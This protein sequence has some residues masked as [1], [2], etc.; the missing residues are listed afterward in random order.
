MYIINKS[1][2]TIAATVN[3]GVADTNYTDLYLV[4]KNYQAY[5]Q[6]INTNFV[7]LLENFS[8][9]TPPLHPI[10]GQLWYDTVSKQLYQFNG[11]GFKNINAVAVNSASPENTQTGDFWYDTNTKQLK[12][13]TDSN[14]W[15]PVA[16]I[17]SSTQKLSG[18]VVVT[19]NDGTG[20]S[21][22]LTYLY[23]GNISIAALSADEFTPNPSIPGYTSFVRGINLSATSKLQGTATNSE[24]LGNVS[25]AGFMRTD[26]DSV[27]TGTIT[28]LNNDGVNIGAANEFFIY[29]DSADVVLE[30]SLTGNVRF[31]V[32]DAS[33]ITYT[34]MTLRQDGT[35]E[36]SYDLL[37]ANIGAT[38]DMQ[39]D[40]NLL[41]GTDGQID[42]TLTAGNVSVVGDAVAQNLGAVANVN[43]ASITSTVDIS[44]AQLNADMITAGTGSGDAIIVAGDIALE[45][46]DTIYFSTGAANAHIG[47]DSGTLVLGAGGEDWLT[48]DSYGNITLLGPV[49]FGGQANNLTIG[50][51]Y[52][53]NDTIAQT[54]IE[55]DLTLHG[56]PAGGFV[57]ADNFYVSGINEAETLRLYSTNESTDPTNG[58]LIVDGGA[59]IARNLNVGGNLNVST[60]LSTIASK[61]KVQIISSPALNSEV[62]VDV[63]SGATK[64]Y[65]ATAAGNWVPN[66][67]GSSTASLNSILNVGDSITC[68]MITTQG[69]TPYFSDLV[70]VDG[71]TVAAKWLAFNPDAG[72]GSSLDVYTYAMIKTGNDQWTVL[73]GLSNFV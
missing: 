59:G 2:G 15:Q 9:N 63:L 21:H 41:I 43:A 55:G 34:A 56:G 35:L 40:G 18:P 12:F 1:D 5:G 57:V 10:T 70:K 13:Y 4:G 61:E 42:G 32:T 8:D 16:P 30:H 14:T 11:T 51:I 60:L 37:A 6:L 64:Y 48:I 72:N 17:Y 71:A 46:T 23:D 25:A 68:S 24:A 47:G 69:A 39:A 22:A 3:D 33:S 54:I 20:N 62:N 36:L 7:R 49:D 67:R 26:A 58:T 50:N 66:F 38:G 31:N 44:T 52:H 29:V 65:T 73:A 19:V 27:T 28:V 53:Y 45:S